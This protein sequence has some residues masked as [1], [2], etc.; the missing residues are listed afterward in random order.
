MRIHWK[1]TLLLVA[2]LLFLGLFS[3]FGTYLLLQPYTQQELVA[4]KRDKLE[5]AKQHL[6]DQV[7]IAEGVILEGLALSKAGE[8]DEARAKERV[9]ATLATMRY[10][11][12]AGYFWVNDIS[13]PIPVMVMHPISPGLNGKKLDD[14]KYNCAMGKKQNLFQAMVEVTARDDQGYVD[15]LWP[16]PNKDGVSEALPKL[17]YVKRIAPW[18]WIVGTGVYIDSIDAAV[19]Q[20]EADSA[21]NFA[22]VISKILLMDLIILV[23]VAIAMGLFVIRTIGNP[24]LGLVQFVNEVA[25]GNLS[26]GLTETRQ[27]EVGLTMAAISNMVRKLGTIFK[28]S[29]NN[30]DTL[31]LS[32]ADLLEISTDLSGGLTSMADRY[33]A[34]AGAAEEMRANMQSI[35][36]AMEESSANISVI[37]GS[38]TN[39]ERG[40]DTISMNTEK[41]KQ[42]TEEVATM[43]AR[44]T[45][46]LADLGGATEEITKISATITEISE[47][48]NLLALNAT[49]EAARAGEAGKGFAVVASE[50]KELANSVASSTK[51]IRG[52]VNR[53]QA[54]TSATVK[55][56]Q[57]IITGIDS[58]NHL[59]AGIATEIEG[60]KAAT[61]EITQSIGQ[62]S[63]GVNEI[64]MNVTQSTQANRSV[65]EDLAHITDVSH[66][67]N[68]A[69]LELKDL[70]YD[71]NVIAQTLSTSVHQFDLGEKKF[72]IAAIKRAHLRWKKN[73]VTVLLGKKKIRADEVTHHTKCD[74]GQWY[75]GQGQVFASTELFQE[76][77]SHH[78]HV[79]SYAREI[80]ELY[81]A[82]KVEVAERRLAS[83]EE[84]RKKLFACLDQMY[85]S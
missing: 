9:L 25:G 2:A 12:G 71:I 3:A 5:E 1:I 15:Y 24:I 51:E 33:T 4:F 18:G 68:S 17:S 22:A 77:G 19:A 54:T 30:A 84:A 21:R 36:A 50:I 23:G 32:S 85:L 60:Q 61:R 59:V 80:V 75:F 74:F 58:V 65:A 13:Q 53:V 11:N 66:Q 49:I 37:A 56:I 46:L 70:S 28:A 72:D 34:I 62:T 82:G 63:Q 29:A 43:A 41:V 7:E 40:I 81:N 55:D 39:M 38:A 35:A 79:H 47:K 64:S 52:K 27:D 26:R 44:T 73:L 20:K 83:F 48:T 42:V 6:R 67:L 16:K 8:M 14:P 57:A 76:I 78:E 45:A 31:T 10:D 69:S